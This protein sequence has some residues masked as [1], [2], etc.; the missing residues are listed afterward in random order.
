LD[1]LDRIKDRKEQIAKEKL[2]L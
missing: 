2:R 1:E